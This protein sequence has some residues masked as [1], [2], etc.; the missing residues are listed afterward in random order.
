MHLTTHEGLLQHIGEEVLFSHRSKSRVKN[1]RGVLFSEVIEGNTRIYILNDWVEG[2]EPASEK[3]RK[4]GYTRSWFISSDHRKFE[5]DDQGIESVYT[6]LDFN[7]LEEV[8]C[9]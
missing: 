6:F 8:L 2:T 5:Y 9:F 3:W 1:R 4:S 7:K